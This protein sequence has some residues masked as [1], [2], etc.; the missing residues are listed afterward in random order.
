MIQFSEEIAYWLTKNGKEVLTLALEILV[1]NNYDFVRSILDFNNKNKSLEPRLKSLALQIVYNRNKLKDYGDWIQEGLF[2]N[3]NVQQASK[4]L[5]ARHH[6]KR[7]IELCDKYHEDIHLLE[8]CSGLGFDLFE[9]SK[10]S[11]KIVS[12]EKDKTV[13]DFCNYNLKIQNINNVELIHGEAQTIINDLKL[14]IFDC[15]WADPSRRDETGIRKLDPDKFHP[16]LSFFTNLK[17]DNLIGIKVNP[18]CG[19]NLISNEISFIQEWISEG[20]ECKEQVIWLNTGNDNKINEQ[21]TLFFLESELSSTY[22][23]AKS[24]TKDNNPKY[25]FD[26]FKNAHYY[27]YYYYSENINPLYLIEPADGFICSSLVEELYQ[28]NDF[29]KVCSKSNYGFS[30]KLPHSSIYFKRF[31]I[32][33][34]LKFNLKKINDLLIKLNWNKETE[35]KKSNFSKDL[36]S[37]RKKLNFI[38]SKENGVIILTQFKN[39]DYCILA[40]R[41]Y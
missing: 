14:D 1:K 29:Y 24:K 40:K 12:I 32:F 38:N 10:V 16:P 5:I 36:V 9:L 26:I 15:I 39:I 31:Q 2:V 18:S 37:I 30:E 35:I 33:F 34:L 6:A 22:I 17:F 11:K 19:V 27:Y 20:N 41:I 13:Y 7:I 28:E 21:K 3:T 23:P 8:I 25:S 4:P